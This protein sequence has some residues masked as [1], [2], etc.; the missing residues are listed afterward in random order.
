VWNCRSGTVYKRHGSGTLL[1]NLANAAL[2]VYSDI[3]FIEQ[4]TSKD[5]DLGIFEQTTA[6]KNIESCSHFDDV[7]KSHE[8]DLAFEDMHGQF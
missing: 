2:L 6:R 1:F 5:L 7:R 8:M 4:L 3:F